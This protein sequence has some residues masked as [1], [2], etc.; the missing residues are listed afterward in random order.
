MFSIIVYQLYVWIAFLLGMKIKKVINFVIYRPYT[1]GYCVCVRLCDNFSDYHMKD[2]LI[3]GG[4]EIAKGRFVVTDGLGPNSPNLCIRIWH[5]K[6]VANPDSKAISFKKLFSLGYTQ[7]INFSLACLNNEDN[8]ES[9]WLECL[10]SSTDGKLKV[11]EIMFFLPEHFPIVGT[12][13]KSI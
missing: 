1:N 2:Y 11:D 8:F 5:E 9:Q 13:N 4:S 7:Q 12:R 3:H 6:L 10:I